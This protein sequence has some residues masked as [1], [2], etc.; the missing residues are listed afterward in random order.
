M[1]QLKNIFDFSQFDRKTKLVWWTYFVLS[2]AIICWSFLGITSFTLNQV[3]FLLVGCAIALIG[4]NLI[5]KVPQTGI[6]LWLRESLILLSLVWLNSAGVVFLVSFASV[7]LSKQF[8]KSIRRN[9]VLIT[10]GIIATF[11]SSLFFNF[12]IKTFGEID[13]LTSPTMS[14]PLL[15]G[16][17]IVTTL[18]FYLVNT[19]LYLTFLAFRTEEGLFTI[20]KE[21]FSWG[22]VTYGIALLAVF[23][24]HIFFIQFGTAIGFLFIPLVFLLNLAN[25]FYNQTLETKD[26]ESIETSRIHL[27]TI[28]ALATAIDARDQVG[29]G[30]ARRVQIY[31][32]GMGEVLGLSDDEIQALRTGALLHDIGKLAVPDHILN[33]PG[34]LT[35][36]EMEKTK[37]HSTV[38]ASILEKV[39]FPYPVVPTVLFHHENWDGSGYPQGLSKEEIPLT[40]R[41]IA[42]ADAYDTIRGARPYRTS[43]SRE[44][45]RRCLRNESGKQYDP[46]LV[47]TFLRYC[48][49]FEQKVDEAGLSYSLETK[50][51]ENEIAVNAITNQSKGNYVEQIK[52]ANREVYTLYEL[53][54][55]F[56]GS[57]SIDET[58]KLFVAKVRELVPF[59]TCAIYL[60]NENDKTAV[61]AYVEGLNTKSLEN[62]RI[63]EGEGATGYVLKNRQ[64]VHNINPALDF[65]FSYSHIAEEFTSMASLP[66]IANEKLIGAISLYSSQL[67]S[68]EDDYMRLL[69]TITRIAADAI[70]KS[71]THAEME[72]R[73]LTDPM[74]GLPNARSLQTHFE[75]EVA[76]ARRTGSPLQ[77]IMF[78]LD[79]FK[80]VNDNFG[81]KVGD[82]LLLEVGK[83]MK[84]QLRDYDFLARYAGDEFVAIVPEVSEREIQELCDRIEKAVSLFY[85][86]VADSVAR[87]GISIGS[88][89][90]PMNGESLDQL[91]VSADQAMYAV[92]A[93]HKQKQR[94]KEAKAIEERQIKELESAVRV[95]PEEL[96][97]GDDV[98]IFDLDES[99]IITNNR[100][101]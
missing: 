47:E 17:L 16:G 58:L 52:R 96:I 9:S 86:P 44:D 54:R 14:L 84:A 12:I 7:A 26:V 33:K 60:Y 75:Q 65:S 1:E 3:I 59:D 30:H 8:S 57:L 92:K 80:A 90:F 29:V 98:V 99:H 85:I 35:P 82:K 56:S 51:S 94:E 11:L 83:V 64:S 88:A 20:W 40:A 34:R 95:M 67:E 62:K 2:L 69:E 49:T 6:V 61:A 70:S 37:I 13:Y 24:T 4:R 71:V 55:I 19:A 74:T 45:A 23:T 66:L 43:L 15:F 27:A 32:I 25:R 100:V 79:G 10:S 5:F 89:G 50:T 76:R 63:K 81:H 31:S 72:N 93:K 77:I 48:N 46:R 97:I 36:A 28:E 73:A 78:D 18:F 41:I 68:Y 87:V 101:N 22:L 42:I 39:N 21:T 53:A 38:G 91:I